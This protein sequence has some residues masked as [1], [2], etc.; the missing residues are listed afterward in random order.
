MLNLF[1][2]IFLKLLPLYAIIGAGFIGGKYLHISKESIANLLI[3]IIGPVVFFGTIAVLP[4]TAQKLIFPFICFAISTIV[5]ISFF[6]LSAYFIRDNRRHILAFASGTGNTGYFGIPVFLIFHPPSDLGTYTL[7]MLGIVIWESFIGYYIIARGH[8]SPKESFIKLL[9]MP[10]IYA[11][12]LGILFAWMR[13]PLPS[14]FIDM[15]ANFRGAFSILGMMIIGLGLSGMRKLEF[16]WKFISLAFA[17]KFIIA[18]A[19]ILTFLCLDRSWLHWIDPIARQTLLIFCVIPLAAV[20]VIYATQLR[21]HPEKAATAVLLSTLFS[22]FYI[23]L[24]YALGL[25]NGVE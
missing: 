18:P 22:L 21:L 13:I 2:T 24:V 19:V 8:Y 10:L 12:I 5:S 3:Y 6:K 11:S 9:K 16:D 1:L 20:T 4:M 17:C 15:V 25:L 14:F 7:G 23:P